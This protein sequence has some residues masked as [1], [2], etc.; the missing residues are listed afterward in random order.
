MP[1]VLLQPL[2]ADLRREG[3]SVDERDYARIRTVLATQRAWTLDSV[4]DCLQALLVHDPALLPTFD[5]V[6]RTFFSQSQPD[7]TGQPVDPDC[8]WADV[9]QLTSQPPT[10][11]PSPA[12]PDVPVTPVTP[13]PPTEKKS[14]RWRIVAAAAVATACG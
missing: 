3:F 14:R 1:E 2:F 9:Q 11:P 12:S 8:V 6:F 5:R 4:R 13:A 7:D 10:L